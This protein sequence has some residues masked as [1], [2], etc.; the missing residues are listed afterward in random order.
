M[1]RDKAGLSK[2]AGKLY[3]EL[4]SGLK[5]AKKLDISEKTCYRL[6]KEEGVVLPHRHSSEAQERKRSLRGDAAAAAA[7]DYRRGMSK[8]DLI[9]K[10]GV[11]IWAIRTAAKVAGVKL[12][13]KGGPTRIFQR[14]GNCKS[15]RP[16]STRMVTNSD[17]G[18]ISVH[19]NN[20]KPV[21]SS[22]W[23]SDA[24]AG[25]TRRS[26]QLEGRQNDRW[27]WLHSGSS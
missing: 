8:A 20:D 5:V 13:P 1:K 10:Y 25:E 3:A 14:R 18:R 2:L 4:G 6:L 19:A 24:E 15:D 22:K 16:V 26:R 12:R 11:G 17:R 23:S 21:A 27:G 7:D 9:E